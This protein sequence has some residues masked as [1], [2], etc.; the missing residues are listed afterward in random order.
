MNAFNA[1]TQRIAL[2]PSSIGWT[3]GIGLALLASACV[4]GATLLLPAREEADNLSHELQLLERSSAKRLS[5][6]P[7][8]ASLRQQFDEFLSSLPGQDQIN[9]QLDLLNK[10]AASHHLTLKN[11]EYRTA[12]GKDGRIARLQIT[13]RTQGSYTD[14]RRFLKE[15]PEVL[16]AMSVSKISMSR[17]KA[18]D[19]TL[20]TNVEFALFYTRAKT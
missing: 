17:Q 20:E 19:T 16:P 9:A 3:G 6:E 7:Q 10:L 18:S 13:V 12:T 8:A 15:L 14:F 4:L 5:Q 11:G 2:I 1:F